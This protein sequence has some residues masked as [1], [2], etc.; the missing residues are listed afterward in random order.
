MDELFGV[1]NTKQGA[2]TFQRLSHFDWQRERYSD[3]ERKGD[4]LR[5]MRQ[6]GDPRVGLLD[7]RDQIEK[8]IDQV[9]RPRVH[10]AK[11]KR[12]GRHEAKEQA[13]EKRVTAKIKERI[14][15]GHKGESDRSGEEGT[16]EEH[17]SAQLGS[18]VDKHHFEAGEA[19]RLIDQTIK[20]GS[21]VRWI[22]TAQQTPAF[23]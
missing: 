3:D 5:R 10:A 17:K 4:V 20:E 19:L 9:L 11:K 13:A 15:S 21:R 7:L 1:T 16:A 23:F 22:Q 6:D 12:K 8:V 2:V 14:E 18:L